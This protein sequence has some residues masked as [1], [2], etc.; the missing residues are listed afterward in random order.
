MKFYTISSARSTVRSAF[1]V[2]N[3][4]NSIRGGGM[5]VQSHPRGIIRGGREGKSRYRFVPAD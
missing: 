5:S 4:S 3:P 2:I 1:M